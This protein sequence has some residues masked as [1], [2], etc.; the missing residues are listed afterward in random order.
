MGPPPNPPK[1]LHPIN[2]TGAITLTWV[3]DV[4]WDP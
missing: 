4:K 1:Q 2:P 3:P